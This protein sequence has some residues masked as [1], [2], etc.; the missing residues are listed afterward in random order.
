M[1]SLY[2]SLPAPAMHVELRSFSAAELRD[3]VRPHDSLVM[4][5]VDQRRLYPARPPSLFA[6]LL[7]LGGAGSGEYA[8]HYVLLAGLD[9]ARGEYAVMDPARP[10]A[11]VPVPCADVDGARRAWGTDEDLLVVPRGI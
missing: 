6:R 10:D 7:G 9:A 2:Q 3:L 8:G 1:L 5:L 11:P 4:A